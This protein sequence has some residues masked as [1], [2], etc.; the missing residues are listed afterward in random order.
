MET[1][2]VRFRKGRLVL[3][4]ASAIGLVFWANC[5]RGDQSPRL[6]GKEAFNLLLMTID[7]LRADH[8][9]AYGFSSART[10]TIDRLAETGI[11]FRNC[12]ASVPLTMPSHATIMTGREP[13]AHRV[14]TDGADSLPESAATLAA[15]MKSSGWET[16]AV[17]GSYRLH[18]KFGLG[19]GFDLYDD[20]LDYGQIVPNLNT[21]VA[22]DK[23][24]LKFRA[25]LE[26]GPPQ[27][28]FAWVNFS[29]PRLPYEP[30]PAFAAEFDR[31]PYSGEVAHVDHYLGEIV[32][33]LES[34]KVLDRT[35]VVIAG[36]HGEALGEHGEFGHG[37]LAYE[38]TLRVPLVV[39]APG[40]FK[41]SQ[42]VERRVR[43]LDLLPSLLELFDL[44]RPAG[45]QGESLWPLLSPKKRDRIADPPVYFE[46]LLGSRE[47]G[48]AP[49]T[50]LIRGHEK[51]I[52]LP[53][54]ELYDLEADP[55]ETDNLATNKADLVR[56]MA[57]ALGK[58]AE[59][60]GRRPD[61]NRGLDPKKG[62]AAV[63]RLRRAGE[64][65]VLGKLDE[66]EGEL[67]AL[68][69]DAV[70][71]TWAE[72]YDYYYLLSKKK[73][74]PAKS[75]GILRQ[76]IERHPGLARFRLSLAQADGDAGRLDAA[77][78]LCLEVLAAEPGLTEARVLLAKVYE[79]KGDV[80]SALSE[81]EKAQPGEPMNAGLRLERA[82]LQ[83][84]L[85]NKAESLDLLKKLSANR[86]LADDPSAD[87]LRAEMARI[88]TRLGEAE[89]AKT[90]LLEIVAGGRADSQVWAQVGLGDLQQ[91]NF[92]KA[93]V[94]LDKALSLD[95]KNALALS[96]LGTYHLTLF[97]QSKRQAD[98]DGAVSYYTRAREAS[99]K[100]VSAING[101][102][103]ASRYAGDLERA[104]ACWAEVLRI[105]P[106]FRDAYFNLGITYLETGRAGEALKILIHC[107]DNYSA[108]LGERE[109]R[110]LEALISEAKK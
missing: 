53:E 20:S 76:A 35:V 74:D 8:V 46:S 49:L 81:L 98:L 4:V 39:Y 89:M 44:D 43:L 33:L 13:P 101:L 26:Q 5:R 88:L 30:P 61:E 32:G 109:K 65:I 97:R 96:G 22:A 78:K 94:S 24:F 31:D 47:M 52:S 91:G 79:R 34:R 57:A 102:G 69:G 84:E 41:K 87:S 29:D 16:C 10:P 105:D 17:V 2:L 67:Q 45:L 82:S 107:R 85:G 40:I 71:G 75:E 3:A 36:S 18:S 80:R 62:M 86:A 90:L 83:A 92:D 100:L 42:A 37:L 73:N 14:R 99:P 21:A 66:A 25:W 56:E 12:Y 108:R 11:V 68:L 28:F 103:V 50:G 55:A 9:G 63:K 72:V 6:K 51:Y 38:P 1:P 60:A 59:K 15:A 106:S 64:K 48:W 7:A 27:K 110:Q 58:H 70:A 19:T 23:V 54:A 93:R 104:V 95:P 77:E